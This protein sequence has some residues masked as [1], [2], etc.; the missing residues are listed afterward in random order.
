[1]DGFAKPMQMF[2]ISG[3]H[4]SADSFKDGNGNS[5]PGN[6]DIE[7]NGTLFQYVD[8]TEHKIGNAYYGWEILLPVADIDPDTNFSPFSPNKGESGL[9]DL[10]V[11]PFML[12]WT[13]STLFGKPYFHRLNAIFFLPT[14]DYDR[15][16]D[17]N[18]GNN[19]WRF[20]PYYAGTLFL[21]PKWELSF[22]LHYMWSSE[23][24]DP[25]PTLLA[26]DT[27]AGE[28]FHM[29]Y[30]ASYAT[31][32]HFRVGIS[33]YYLNQMSRDR[34]DGRSVSN[35][36]EKVYGLGPGFMWKRPGGILTVNSYVE[37]GAEN[38]PEGYKLVARY[39]WLFH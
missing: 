5:L 14:G 25:N 32:D 23:N 6:N 33:G 3:A 16:N 7:I 18:I 1:M 20:N 27:Q 34:I 15:N 29:N 21:S 22:R 9:G 24:D 12:Q 2:Q 28:V 19:T 11:S 17:V 35:S 8:L 31:S 36:G 10:I 39:A 26:N 38:R 13:D 4:F 37:F 30:A